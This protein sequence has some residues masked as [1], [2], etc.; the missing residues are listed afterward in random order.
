MTTPVLATGL[1]GLVGTRVRD[2][3]SHSFDFEDLS[4]ATDI[5]ITQIQQVEK[6]FDAS[7]ARVVLHLAAKTDVDSCED[8]KLLAEEGQAWRVNVIGTENIA[9]A[10]Q[11]FGKRVIYIS[12]DFVFDGT[13]ESYSEEDKPNP[14]SWYGYTKF[15]G[16]E[17]LTS[18]DVDVTIVRISYPYRSRNNVREDFVHRLIDTMKNNKKVYG[19]TDHILT[20]TFIDDIANNLSLFLSKNLPG[21]Y[22]LVGSSSMPTIEAVK[23]VRDVYHLQAEIIPIDRQTYF[24]NRAFRP[25]K[26]ALK[27][28]KIRKLGL[29]M[30][31]F[32]DGLKEIRK[33]DS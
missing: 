25:F 26:L 17:K 5:D 33:Q 13:K 31:A 11:K 21:I 9:A 27:N 14:I 32:I 7:P 6:A 16:E 29:K 22:H 24:R 1:S 28:D 3:L 2:L 15:I 20:P 12:T 10:A 19:L 23:L 30:S 8:D 18:C 4:L